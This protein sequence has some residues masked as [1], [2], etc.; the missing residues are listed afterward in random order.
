MKTVLI[1]ECQKLG[2][3]QMARCVGND[4]LAGVVRCFSARHFFSTKQTEKM[5]GWVREAVSASP[6][7]AAEA[8]ASAG[9]K[10]AKGSAKQLKEY[11]AEIARLKT[12]LKA[13]QE[14][15]AAVEKIHSFKAKG[16]AKAKAEPKKKSAKPEPEAPPAKKEKE[17]SKKKEEEPEKGKGKGKGKGT[18]V[19]LDM[20]EKGE[21]PRGA[22]CKYCKLMIEKFGTNDYSDQNC[23][24]MKMTGTCKF[25]D[26]C[27]YIHPGT[28]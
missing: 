7:D 18:I 22:D 14:L 1:A 19:C 13:Y 12:Q 10:D 6:D 28:A 3:H 11:E 17:K 23:W 8:S 27:K 2:R 24:T 9:A 26:K 20:K 15:E 25:G 5:L 16:D 21:C 4:R